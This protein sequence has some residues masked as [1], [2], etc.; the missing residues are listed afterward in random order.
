MGL[1]YLDDRQSIQ[2]AALPISI[3]SAANTTLDSLFA[4][5]DSKMVN[6]TGVQA[7][8]NKTIGLNNSGLLS[9][10]LVFNEIATPATNPPANT[11]AL[12]SKSDGN[13]YSLNSSGAE[14]EV[15]GASGGF[16]I[17]SVQQSF[18]TLTQ[19]Q[20]QLGSGWIISDGSA[21]P[22]STYEVIVGASTITSSA[23]ATATVTGATI[24][25]STSAFTTTGNINSNNQVTNIVSPTALAV[26]QII[27]GPNIP[28][29]TTVSSIDRYNFALPGTANGYSF[30]VHSSTQRTFTVHS[31]TSYIFTVSPASATVGSTYTNNG[32]T[33][34][35]LSTITGGTT[36]STSSTADPNPSGTL[37]LASGSGDA[38]ITFSSFTYGGANATSGATYTNNGQTFTVNTTLTNG[39]SLSTSGP[40]DPLASGTLTLASGTGDATI[41]FTS[42]AYGGANAT[43]GATYTNSGNTYT[44]TTTITGGTTL[45]VNSG[46]GV[47]APSGI[48]TKATGSG[49]TT[50][51]FTSF[52]YLGHNATAGATYTNNGHTFTV[53]STI[54]DGVALV[55]TGTG[56]PTTSGTLT[57]ATGTGDSTIAFSS[58]TA[59]ITMSASATA[60]TV[61]ESLNFSAFAVSTTGNLT[62]GSNII[63]NVAST[64]GVA[65]GQVI[66]VNG[67]PPE[68]TVSSFAST[69]VP[70]CRG[71]VLRGQ[72]NG[73]SDGFQDPANPALRVTERD[74][75]AVNGLGINPASHNHGVNAATNS[76][77]IPGNVPISSSAPAN[78]TY[79][80]NFTTLGL[81]GDA[82]T[83]VKAIIV[84]TF[85]R[86]N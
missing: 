12:Y 74:T 73:R 80:S 13:F 71:L 23:N 17:G 16:A 58:F 68:S 66:D 43:T 44:V 41:T 65:T 67:I 2:R 56:V 53:V 40:N 22:G 32:H 14:K 78:Y 60:T 70:D 54:V 81:V 1:K 9:N 85:I 57:L 47:P 55:C 84:N 45:T 33:Y 42:F 28:A 7:L 61:G 24:I 15:G 69:T 35:V 6:L 79:A 34:T 82:E 75:T 10:S 8:A 46:T 37:T 38:T 20:T 26:G 63:T 29:D 50:I 11:L 77:T 59:N 18:L 51:D 27:S 25:L 19:F 83:R 72:N 86:I 39:V 4:L 30:A 36:L 31:S 48:L 62:N 5:I 52:T 49:D 64:V 76:N 3:G 21:V